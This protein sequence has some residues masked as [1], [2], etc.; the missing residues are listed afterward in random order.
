MIEY[1]NGMYNLN[2]RYGF[3][4]DLEAH[5]FKIKILFDLLSISTLLI[6]SQLINLDSTF[7]IECVS[8]CVS[9]PSPL[10]HTDLLYE[11]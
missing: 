8:V 6:R 11:Y 9:S 4:I 3:P 2:L 7:V 5:K 10:S 1:C